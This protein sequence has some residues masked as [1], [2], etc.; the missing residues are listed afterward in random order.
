MRC[1]RRA[2][3]AL[4]LLLLA[5]TSAHATFHLWSMDELFSS[6]DATVQF[7]EMT[8]LTGGQEFMGGHT[9]VATDGATT[10]TFVIPSNLPGDTAGRRMIFGT[11]S[12]AALGVVQPDF[13]LP[14]GFFFPAGGTV[15]FAEGADTWNHG[16]L[17]ADGV[18]A[19]DRS[20]AVIVNSPTNFLRATG[21]VDLA[22]A[23]RNYQA[24]WWNAPGG[25]ESG[26][27]VNI[28]HQGD[29][30]FA[31]WFTYDDAGKGLW[32]VMSD[33]AKTAPDTYAGAL[34]RT[35]GPAFSAEPWDPAKVAVTQVGTATFAFS[36]GEHGTFTYTV[37]GVTQSKAIERQVFAA[38]VPACSAGGTPPAMPNYQ[39]LWWHDPP[40]SE[41]GWGVNLTHQGDTLFATWF[42]YGADGN[43]MWLV[44]SDGAKTGTA[45]YSG[46]L[47]RTTGPAFS[48]QPWNPAQVTVTPVGMA[49]FA[50]GDASHGT[51]TYTVDGITQSKAITR[52]T[53]ASPATVCR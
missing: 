51:F 45:T 34:Y 44:M 24:L 5:A 11:R 25:S 28:A 47:Y 9:L 37:N 42:T 30:L 6:A 21:S 3:A 38:P 52:Q 19:L 20:G 43:G 8:A 41:S 40:G 53:F 39:D 13:V 23:P 22:A 35:T 27:G 46:P 17:P 32:L 50:F 2:L 15:R 26:W 29:T 18:H 16:P 48:A 49:T 7:L 36:D 12:F 31:T 1:F 10:H 4:A 14:D 33:G